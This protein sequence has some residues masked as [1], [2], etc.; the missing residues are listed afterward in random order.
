[1][2]LSRQN[3]NIEKEKHQE[4]RTQVRDGRNEN[5]LRR[6]SRRVLAAPYSLLHRTGLLSLPT[7]L[8]KLQAAQAAVSNL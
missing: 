3:I 5:V 6:P 1:M 8:D 2:W 4:N 7:P